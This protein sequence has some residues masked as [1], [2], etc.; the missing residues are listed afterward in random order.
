MRSHQRSANGANLA[1]LMHLVEQ[2]PSQAKYTPKGTAQIK[3]VL[4]K[5]GCES[6]ELIDGNAKRTD[7]HVMTPLLSTEAMRPIASVRRE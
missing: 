4:N 7:Q 6:A 5:R 2:G 1:H 3:G